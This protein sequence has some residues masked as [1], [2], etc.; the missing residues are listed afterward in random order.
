MNIEIINLVTVNFYTSIPVM[1]EIT[2]FN[3][4]INPLNRS[5]FLSIIKSALVGNKKLIQIGVNSASINKSDR[6]TEFRQAVNSADLVNIDGISVFLALRFLG[7]KVPERVAT[8]DLADDVI[9]MAE[10][11]GFSVF[12]F[13][14]KE[15]ALLSCKKKLEEAFPKIKITGSRNGYY[16]AEEETSIVNRINDT[17]PDILLIAMPSPKKELFFYKYGHQ[18]RARYILGVGGYFDIIAGFTRRAPGWIQNI[19]MEWFY[20]FIQ[21]PRR[22]W[23]RYI[24]GNFRFI[25][26]V[27]KE[28]FA[29]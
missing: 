22:L 27:I 24:L 20:R 18:L 1:K 15:S 25:W 23:R 12:L 16:N 5:E 26:L 17:G 29:N 6:D 28:K 2:A 11:E 4:K 7:F 14:A 13:G 10:K 9:A 21:E 19:G 3:L 8:P